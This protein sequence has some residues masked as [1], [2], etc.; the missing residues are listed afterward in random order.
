[1]PHGG[2]TNAAMDLSI[3]SLYRNL[4]VFKQFSSKF[5]VLP[6]LICL[7]KTRL[8]AKYHQL[9]QIIPCYAKT[10][11]STWEKAEE[12]LYAEKILY[13][14]FHADK[15]PMS[16]HNGSYSSTIKKSALWKTVKHFCGVTTHSYA[17]G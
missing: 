3:Y 2:A 7:Q 14:R 15:H 12:L 4:S 11:H 17:A 6:D 8:N 10:D 9:F 13:S 5:E 16:K 1:M